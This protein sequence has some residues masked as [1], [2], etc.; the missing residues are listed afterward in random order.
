MK[1]L[2]KS[3]ITL[4]TLTTL[5]AVAATA[6]TTAVNTL[7]F[8]A[9]NHTKHTIDLNGTAI[10][11]RAYEHIV[12]V[13][14]PIDAKYQQLN[15]YIPEAYFE[16]KT[17]GRWSAKTAPI[18]LPNNIGGYMPAE[19]GTVGMSRDGKAPNSAAVALSKGYVVAAPGARGR[20]LQDANGSYTGKAPA[21]IVD[22]KA[23]VRYI[24]FNDSAMP[25]DANKIISNGTS[26]GGA[27]S[28]LL[29]A[30]GNSKDYAQ[31][32]KA[33]GA[34]NVR[35][36]V[37]AVSAYC[38]IANLENADAAYEWQFSGVSDYKKMVMNGM[39]DFHMQR[40]EVAGTLTADE[41]A[42][43]N[44]LKKLFPA[45]LNSLKLKDKNGALLTLDAAGNGSFKQYIAS[46]VTASAQ[47]A[48]KQG[49]DLSSS[50]WLN[51]KDHTVGSIDF[52]AYNR[53]ITR[54]KTPPAFDALDLSSGE[55]DLFG[56]AK[57]K[58]RHFTSYALNNSKTKASIAD[59]NT[60]RLMNP[61]TYIG[62]KGGDS[63][64]HWRIRHGTADRDTSLAISAIM[65]LTLNNTGKNVDYALPWN[66]P[67]S[68]DYDLEE[69]FAWV[70]KISQ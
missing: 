69:L 68:G 45:Y 34:A 5:N 29:G 39:I 4:S 8:N 40:K 57:E 55:N 58:S 50:P 12:Y 6:T 70:E 3:F 54:M 37:F 32:L 17:V 2:F 63:S 47:E 64:A 26:A 16:G 23:A 7:A 18:F 62:K 33:L 31:H 27:M 56:T 38:P 59:A 51:I 20:T 28:A 65:A 1:H 66:V 36:D 19:A 30:S 15:I 42:T 25:G 35:D 11:Y 60:I 43:A 10:K 49:A 61:M 24:R 53:A 48:L 46:Q 44:D 22:L 14:N 9:Q 41:I 21:A 52:D 67:H 13:K